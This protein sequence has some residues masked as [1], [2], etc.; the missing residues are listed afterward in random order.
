MTITAN[1]QPFHLAPG[2]TLPEFL[3]SIGLSVGL[4]VIERN[5]QAL[6]PS[7]AQTTI[8]A[9]GDTLEIVKIVAGG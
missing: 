5:R 7:E 4:V 9:P 3:A 2:A 6:S 1:G 8:L